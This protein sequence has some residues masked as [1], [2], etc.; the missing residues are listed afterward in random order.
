MQ[1]T[2]TRVPAVIYS[3]AM[4]DLEPHARFVE[5][6]RDEGRPGGVQINTFDPETGAGAL[7]QVCLDREAGL[8]LL[9]QLAKALTLP[10]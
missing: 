8:V 9:A 3:G 6:E 4:D 7:E 5:A 2:D 10:E 1:A